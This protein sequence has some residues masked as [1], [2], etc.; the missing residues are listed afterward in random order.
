MTMMGEPALVRAGWG[1]VLLAAPSRL[2]GGGPPGT[3][4]RWVFR[5]LGARQL[6]QAAVTAWRPTPVVLAAGAA[7]DVLHAASMAALAVGDARWRGRAA[8][9]AVVAGCL[10]AAGARAAARAGART[11][12]RIGW[13][14]PHHLDRHPVGNGQPTRRAGTAGR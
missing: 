5:V 12:V 2:T 10:A 13:R 1:L 4:R 8:A 7:T 9:D 14:A 11:P 3:R 6:L